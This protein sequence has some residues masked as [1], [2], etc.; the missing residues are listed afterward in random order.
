MTLPE[1]DENVFD[2]FVDWLYHRRYE[3]A[4]PPESAPEDYDRFMQPVQLF[5]LA[6]KYDVRKL[7]NLVLYQLFLTLK[8]AKDSPALT[9]FAYAYKHTSQSSTIRKVLADHL[10]YSTELT[11]FSQASIQTWFR[12]HPDISVDVITS[13]AKY[14]LKE[15]DP[16]IEEMPE[17]Y[18]EKEPEGGK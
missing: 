10:T 8:H 17:N 5:V 18:I 15:E 13:F 16:F 9:T 3:I 4:P 1:D 12:D 6:D 2:L 7:K 11:W 14:T